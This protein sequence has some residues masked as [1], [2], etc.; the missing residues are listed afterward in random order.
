MA[1]LSSRKQDALDLAWILLVLGLSFAVMHFTYEMREKWPGVQP[2]PSDSAALFYGFG[3]RQFSYRNVGIILQNAGDTG[4]RT[5]NFKDYDYGIIEDWL[6]LSEKLDFSANYVP[7]LAAYYFGSAKD[8]EQ[9]RHLLD[10]LARVGN[11]S[12]NE[13][14]RW[15]AQAV[16][17]A[18]FQV[19][20]Q[21]KALDL[22]NQLAALDG[23]DMPTWTKIMPAYVNKAKGDKK[24]ARDLL[25]LTI[26]DPKFHLEQAE[27]N[28]NCWYINENLREEG[29]ALDQN[30]VF[31]SFCADYLKSEQ[32]TQ[33]SAVMK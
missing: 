10:Y 30:E 28:Q 20:D 19:K 33:K 11:D 32:Q 6:K 29:D 14:W 31:T 25:L 13:R 22:A 8:P 26:A 2:A 23:P 7:S 17:L 1:R 12:K 18:R 3:D 9:V 5:T 16:Y 15:L 27:I 4:G 21:Q 24:E